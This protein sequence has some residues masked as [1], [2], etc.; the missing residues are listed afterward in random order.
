[1]L[2]EVNVELAEESKDQPEDKSKTEEPQA[3][4]KGEDSDDLFNSENLDRDMESRN[5][6]IY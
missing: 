5:T 1:M 6:S 4:A 3:E 2:D